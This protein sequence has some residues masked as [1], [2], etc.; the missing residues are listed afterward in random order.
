MARRKFNTDDQE[1]TKRMIL[2]AMSFKAMKGDTQA[3]RI[4][5]DAMKQQ[6]TIETQMRVIIVDD[7][8][9]NE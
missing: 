5:L 2:K 3:A 9:E 1:Q 8:T 7:T 6:Q 4:V